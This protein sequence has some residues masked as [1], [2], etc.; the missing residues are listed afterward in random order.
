MAESLFFCNHMVKIIGFT[1]DLKSDL[2]LRD[3]DPPDLNAEFDSEA[4]RDLV[5]SAIEAAGHKV[6]L[7]GNVKNLLRVLPDL[8]VDMVF[9]I[10]EGVGSRNREAQVP[11]IL[12]TFGI[13]YVG[14]DG[15]TMSLA[16]DKIMTK[17]VIAQ[18]GI[19]T[20]SYIGIDKLDDLMNLDH[21]RFPMIVKLRNEGTSKGLSSESVVRS[22]KELEKR[23]D[24]LFDRYNNPLLIVEELISGAELTVPIIGNSHL[25]ILPPIQVSINGKTDLGEE[26]YTFE[27]VRSLNPE[28]D[29]ICPANIDK[30]LENKLVDLAVR[31]YR[32][33]GC[34]DFGRIDFR[35]DHD[36]NPY[37]LEINPLPSLSPEDVFNLAPYV[38]GSDY[39]GAIKKIIDAALER[40]GL[41]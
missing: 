17:K 24:Y 32:A 1:Y 34:R 30:Q 14:S 40:Y 33:V 10:C 15:L 21:M 3:G 29:Y 20:P 2:P 27:R 19:P 41:N 4:T 8:K 35:V 26:I 38:V 18:E 9:N 12:E 31:T 5:K 13:P 23:V 39:N 22:N 7:I 28:L 36:N 11:V 16:L 37:V 25:E 6:I